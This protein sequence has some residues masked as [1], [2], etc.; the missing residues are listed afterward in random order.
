MIAGIR[1]WLITLRSKRCT[2]R[3]P[4]QSSTRAAIVVIRAA[5]SVGAAGELES[6]GGP[7]GEIGDVTERGRPVDVAER[8]HSAQL[9]AVP[10]GVT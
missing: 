3:P 4:G 8:E 10:N 9:D 5:A 1:R 2:P 7:G 6:G